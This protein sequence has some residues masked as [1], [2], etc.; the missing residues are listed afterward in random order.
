M[1]LNLLFLLLLFASCKDTGD[2]SASSSYDVEKKVSSGIELNIYDYQGLEPLLSTD[3][4][5]VYVVNFWATWCAPCVKELPFFEKINT[6]YA[7]RNV[8]VLLVSLD[9]PNKYDSQLK[10]FIID[11]GLKSRV[12]ALNDPDANT[13]IPKVS[14][15]WSGAIPATLIF[16]KDKRMFYEKAFTFEELQAEVEQFLN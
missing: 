6:E 4:K 16:N 3:S 2:N 5:M 13:W 7:H 10:P 15:T 12:V 11:K 9:F 1:R 8:E 14:E